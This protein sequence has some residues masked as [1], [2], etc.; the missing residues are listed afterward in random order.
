MP[1]LLFFCKI[2]SQISIGSKKNFCLSFGKK[3][4]HLAS[5]FAVGCSVSPELMFSGINI[6][7][8]KIKYVKI[9]ASY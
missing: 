3:P 5:K 6:F 4:A 1:D 8:T 9:L 7:K 2:F